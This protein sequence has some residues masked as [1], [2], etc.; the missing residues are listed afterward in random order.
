MKRQADVRPR[1]RFLFWRTDFVGIAM[2]VSGALLL[3]VNFGLVSASP[4][5]LARL[6]GIL[7]M[8][9]GLGFLFFTGAGGWLSWFIIPAGVLFTIGVVTLVLG[10]GMFM[11]PVAAE[12]TTAGFGLTFLSV[13]L[14]RRNQWWAL[15]PAGAF[16]GSALWAFVGSRFPVV[17]WH[18]V[19]VVLCVG[20]SFFSIY[21]SAFEKRRM[22]WCLLVGFLVVS[23]ALA[24]LL[25][26]LL[27]RWL[28]LWPLALVVAG[29][30]VPAAILLV[31]RR[32]R[33]TAVPPA[34]GPTGHA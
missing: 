31:D 3:A 32:R 24:Y 22:R 10:A 9:A 15:I 20:L 25:A 21:V 5:V 23:A 16:L 8:V 18:P 29:L 14:T 1:D 7:F 26:L 33:R 28:A 6:L 17:G 2:M 4:F 19:P 11:S 13:F 12:L 27:T 34:A 30:C